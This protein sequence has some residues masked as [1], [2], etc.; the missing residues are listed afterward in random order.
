MRLAYFSPL[1]PSKSG[2]ADYSAE[3]LP[4]LAQ[5]AEVTVFVEQAHEGRERLGE[6]IAVRQAVHFEAIDRE[7]PFDLCIYHQGNNP[8]HDFVYEQAMRRPGL[9]VLHEHCLHHLITWRTLG[10]GDEEAY[11]REMFHA[12][13]RVGARMAINR[14]RAI[15]SEYQQFLLPLNHRLINRSLGVAVHNQYAVSQ[16]ESL[17]PEIPVEVIPHHLSPVV[18]EMDQ[19]DPLECRRSLGLPEDAFLVGS[20]GFVSEPKRIPIA[21]AA[22]QRLLKVL[23]NARYL[24]VGEDHWKHRAQPLIEKMGLRH[25]VRL[26]GYVTE[27]DFYRY[28]RAIDVLINLRYPTA[29]ETSGTL[30]RSLGAGKPVLVTDFGQ[31]RDLPDDVCLKVA[32]GPEEE[33]ELGRR[34]RTLAFQPHFREAVGRRA[35]AW[36]RKE[37]AIERSAE[38]YL[39]LARRLVEEKRPVLPLAETESALDLPADRLLQFSE[40]EGE[41]AIDEVAEFFAD[42]PEAV[43]YLR[44]HRRRLLETLRLTP[45][46]DPRARILELSSYLQL[47]ALLHR[48]ARYGE[49]L[50]TNWWEGP[51]A[52]KEMSLRHARTGE[53]L[54]F[55]MGNVDVERQ[56]LPFPDASINVVL[57][58]E[59]IEHLRED[60]MHMLLEIHRVLTWGGRLILTTPNIAS[61]HSY[62]ALRA[63]KSP[64]IYGQYNRRHPADRHAREYTPADVR[65]ALE[66]AGLLVVHLETRDMWHETREDL[67]RQLDRTRVPR[68]WRGDNIF[69]VGRKL[70]HQLIRYPEELYD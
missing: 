50:V 24:I 15:F 11:R 32:P 38:K 20:F 37:C 14:R 19:V 5:E 62:E 6:K 22:F 59:L 51:P 70:S 46:G 48:H 16:L 33:I 41:A 47:P 26:T 43:G 29:G 30:I 21:L 10:Q 40:E 23:P 63:G 13:G 61:A 58:C 54:H 55:R 28:L 9:L 69:A 2:I 44:T 64:Y 25:A 42:R 31:F 17:R 57:C 35:A 3:L 34:L 68:G 7:A 60:P 12:Y 8:A 52:V 67:L 49:V 1:P 27:K 56:R 53:T 66:S 36:V 18:A 45:V 39:A 4:Y 65:A